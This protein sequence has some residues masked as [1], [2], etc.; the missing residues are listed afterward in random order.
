MEYLM[1][2]ALLCQV[3]SSSDYTVL[4]T[5]QLECQQSYVNCVLIQ[6]DEPEYKTRLEKCILK[7]QP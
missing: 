1:A 2:I 5:K 7:R 4:K 6:P 3:S